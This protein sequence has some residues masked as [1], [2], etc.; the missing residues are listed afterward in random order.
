VLLLGILILV[1]ACA[2]EP[3]TTGETAPTQAVPAP[4]VDPD[5]VD[6]MIVV[7]DGDETVERGSTNTLVEVDL[8][9]RKWEFV[10]S[11]ITVNQGD[12]VRLIITSIDVS[13][14]FRQADL[15]INERLSP[16]KT[17][18]VEFVAEEKGTFPFFCTVFCGSGHGGMRGTIVVN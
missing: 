2:S 3:T 11:T 10:P 9:A 18:E 15:G 7:E 8:V 16:G 5:S 6:E 1:S 14:G 4:G 13:H 17:T 12:T